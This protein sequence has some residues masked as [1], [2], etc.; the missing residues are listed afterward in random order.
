MGNLSHG[1]EIGS[2]FAFDG[3]GRA[4]LRL[5][6]V[7]RRGRA[8]VCQRLLHAA[9]TVELLRAGVAGFEVLGDGGHGE[10]ADGAVEVGGE[11]GADGFTRCD[12]ARCGVGDF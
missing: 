7:G 10:A 4:E 9:Q 2:A 11:L 5:K 12:F 6:L 3:D 1:G 8:K